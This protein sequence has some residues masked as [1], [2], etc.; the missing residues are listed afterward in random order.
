[1]ENAYKALKGEDKKWLTAIENLEWV[2]PKNP[3]KGN[4]KWWNQSRNRVQDFQK[5]IRKLAAKDD[6]AVLME[7][8]VRDDNVFA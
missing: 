2:D 1:M 4:S 3:E 6:T 7:Q 5:A 8:W